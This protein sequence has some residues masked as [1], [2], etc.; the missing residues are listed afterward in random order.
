M[1]APP[2][3]AA[4]A[5]APRPWTGMFKP[6]KPHP[7]DRASALVVFLVALPLCLGIALASGA[8]LSS[9]LVAGVI[10]GVVIGLLSG[11][12]VMVSGPAAGLTAVVISAIAELGSFAAFLPA[13]VIGGVI[14]VV[15]G[16]ARAGI[17][18]FFVPSA[19]I[20]GMLSAIGIILVLKQVP[21]LVGYD[22]DAMGDESFVQ[23]DHDNTF[24]ALAHAATHIQWGALVVGAISLGLLLLWP[25]IKVGPLRKIPAPLAVV[26]AG[27][28]LSELFNRLVPG[29]A[30]GAEHM[31]NLP[32]PAT[33]IGW[34][35]ELQ[36][37]DWSVL[38]NPATWTVGLTIGLVASIE[39]LLSL[40]ASDRIDAQNRVSNPDR[41][42][43]AQGIGN[44]LSGLIGGLPVTGVIVRSSANVDAGARTRWSAVYHGAMLLVAI[45][46]IPFLLNRIP[47][48]SLAAILFLVGYNLAKPQIAKAAWLVGTAYFTPFV[49]TVAAIL[50]TDLLRGVI[51]GTVVA[52]FFI[53]REHMRAPALVEASP[54]GAVLKR[55]T[56][57][58]QLTFLHKAQ[59]QHAL[60]SLPPGSRVELDGRECRYID[61]D[62]LRII[63]AYKATATQ[64]R[65]DYRLVGI[66]ELPGAELPD[67]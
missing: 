21:H 59:V 9:G 29:L 11:S 38:S 33:P 63:H 8:P 47:L 1:D 61:F 41:E 5:A 46:A 13:V 52:V 24:A 27:V 7:H 28:A 43:I 36:L 3:N 67:H 34:L 37:P 45:L 50:F 53:L 14:Q 23:P 39:T 66:P 56:L 65:V 25:R 18:A 49:V 55:Y 32:T 31:V 57:P 62:V 20:K 40:E 19:V 2:A 4:T 54:P 60:E 15:L 26:L 51:I 35:S 58:D 48:S 44:T 42:L 12:H 64:A 6:G 10:G 30:I 22:T 17:V 16:M